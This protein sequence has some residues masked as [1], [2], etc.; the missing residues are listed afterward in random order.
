MSLSSPLFNGTEIVAAS[1]TGL[2][3]PYG[4]AVGT[5]EGTT[6]AQM[7]LCVLLSGCVCTHVWVYVHICR[8]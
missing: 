6:R 1:L 5:L 7:D 2:W 4:D 8:G 3:E